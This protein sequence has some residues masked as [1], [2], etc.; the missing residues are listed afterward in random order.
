MGTVD[1]GGENWT[2]IRLP[3]DSNA[4]ALVTAY[5]LAASARHFVWYVESYEWSF[6]YQLE[7]ALMARRAQGDDSLLQG[8]TQWRSLG[9]GCCK[10]PGVRFLF[11]GVAGSLQECKDNCKK[12]SDCGFV[13]HGE[14]W[15][16][17][18]PSTAQCSVPTA[19]ADCGVNGP[20]ATRSSQ[21]QVD[22]PLP[23]IG[24]PT[25]PLSLTLDTGLLSSLRAGTGP[26]KETTEGS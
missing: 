3:K 21:C 18:L 17:A 23:R 25:Q 6:S 15:C 19:I 5:D 8:A 26:Q 22:I 20:D 16:V 12:F 10:R 7:S 24:F 13:M 11:S 2:V 9:R 1:H 14:N 4:A